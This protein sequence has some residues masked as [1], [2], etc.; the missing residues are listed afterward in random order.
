MAWL[1][2]Y[3]IIISAGRS[4]VTPT[5]QGEKSDCQLRECCRACC[6]SEGLVEILA[7]YDNIPLELKIYKTNLLTQTQSDTLKYRN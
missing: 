5:H 6:W 7:D 1:A 3:T 2:F 4:Q